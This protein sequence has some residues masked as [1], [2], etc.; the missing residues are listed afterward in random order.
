MKGKY[1]QVLLGCPLFFTN[2]PISALISLNDILTGSVNQKNHPLL[3]LLLSVLSV[4][5]A[6]VSM[7]P[8][9]G[10]H[11]NIVSLSDTQ[12]FQQMSMEF[13]LQKFPF[14]VLLGTIKVETVVPIFM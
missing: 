5:V 14:G 11:D 3:E 4:V 8:K 7:A 6:V 9:Q 13:L 2:G 1:F 10:N 12:F